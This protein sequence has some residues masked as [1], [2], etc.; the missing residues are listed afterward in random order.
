MIPFRPRFH[1]LK[2]NMALSAHQRRYL[3]QLAHPLKPVVTVG[4]KG[5]TE[6]VCRELDLTLNQH[7]L[8]KIRLA[9][10]RAQR[11]ADLEKL[12]D[13]SGA[14]CVQTIGHVASVYRPHPEQ[15]RLALPGAGRA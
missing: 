14:Q 12:L 10:D 1:R 13:A 4:A 7:E 8:L 3:R 15:P 11:T 9:G 2:L 6:A 5:A